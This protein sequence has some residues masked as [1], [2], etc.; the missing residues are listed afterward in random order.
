[1]ESYNVV[2]LD[3][4]RFKRVV[5][6]RQPLTALGEVVLAEVDL[7]LASPFYTKSPVPERMFYG[8]DREI[9]D[10]RSKIKTHS[11]ALIGGRRIGKTSTLHQ[12]E[13]MLHVPDS[14]YV[15][16]YLDCHNSMQYTHFFNSIQ[17]RWG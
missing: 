5:G 15:P 17:R 13:R 9:K 1:N 7:T 11:V 12:I 16:Y 4:A 6:S 8:R 14:G 2:I 10:V 3:E